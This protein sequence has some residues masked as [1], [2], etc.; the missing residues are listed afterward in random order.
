MATLRF[1][2]TACVVL[3]MGLQVSVAQAATPDGVLSD[4]IAER[5]MTAWGN[6][7]AGIIVRVNDGVVEMWGEAPSAAAAD[8]AVTIAKNTVGVREVVSHLNA[9]SRPTR[10]NSQQQASLDKPALR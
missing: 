5:V 2:R 6:Q 9:E 7:P 8:K 4:S 10:D 3:A 1:A